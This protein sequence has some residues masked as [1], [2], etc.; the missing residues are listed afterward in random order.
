[1]N[2]L[3]ASRCLHPTRY[4]MQLQNI[5][6]P[7]AP[8]IRSSKSLVQRLRHRA[9]QRAYKRFEDDLKAFRPQCGAM[10]RVK[11]RRCHV[12]RVGASKSSSTYRAVGFLQHN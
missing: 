10:P 2:G 8:S 9:M 11:G 12:H 1:M 4:I 5:F 3:R 6:S 7:S